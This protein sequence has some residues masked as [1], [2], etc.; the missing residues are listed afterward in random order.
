VDPLSLR[1]YA[2]RRWADL[3]DAKRAH[4]G[5]V[6]RTRGWR[7]VWDAAQGLLMHARAVRPDFPDASSR[8]EDL[9]HHRALKERIDRAADAFSSR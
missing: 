5:G 2:G 8:A 6:Y 7:V 1:E 9:A 4:W 3:Q